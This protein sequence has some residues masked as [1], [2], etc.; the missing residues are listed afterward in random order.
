MA[1][2]LPRGGVDRNSGSDSNMVSL[3][4]RLPRGGVDRNTRAGAEGVA[5]G[6]VASR[7]EAWIETA[8]TIYAIAA[9]EVASRAE[10]WIE[11][12]IQSGGAACGRVAS[13][14]E[15]WIETYSA[16][17]QHHAEQS[18]PARRRGSKLRIEKL[19]RRVDASPPARR[20]GSKPE[21][22]DAIT[23]EGRRLPRGG[24]DRNPLLHYSRGRRLVA[25]P[26][27]GVDRNQPA[28]VIVLVAA[29]RLPRGGVDRNALVT[30]AAQHAVVAS[31][32][33][34]WIET[35]KLL[36]KPVP[37]NVASRAEAWIETSSADMRS[38]RV[39]GRLPRGGVDRNIYARDL[40]HAN[41]KSP[42]ARRAWIETRQSKGASHLCRVASRAEAWIETRLALA[43]SA[44]GASPPARRRGS[45]HAGLHHHHLALESPPA[46][47]RGSK[48]ATTR[49]AATRATSPPARR[50][51]SKP[52]SCGPRAMRWTSP[53]A[54][55]RG[56]KPD[57]GTG[58][59]IELPVASRA[60]A[61]IETMIANRP[62]RNSSP[63]PEL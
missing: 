18:P 7:A 22:G 44:P 25:S 37:A 63:P 28:D 43:N 11:T 29:C 41:R 35:I 60:E 27:G 38:V 30:G 52:D 53:P 10:A 14:A 24:V 20:R 23:I 16:K 49:R 13:R 48:P 36:P 33:E 17:P 34:A 26:R 54:R 21:R 1:G 59:K 51:G 42:P 46:R 57:E 45:K 4:C 9:S 12:C 5:G 50:R 47:R 40:T 31:R 32:A 15:A 61:W 56:S 19:I 8:T 2:R 55:R 58:N 39:A 3:I 6:L 62:A